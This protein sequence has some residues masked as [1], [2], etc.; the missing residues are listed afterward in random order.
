MLKVGLYR[1]RDSL[2]RPNPEIQPD[3]RLNILIIVNDYLALQATFLK[4]NEAR[5][6]QKMVKIN[7]HTKESFLIELQILADIQIY[8]S[9]L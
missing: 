8:C 7:I 4:K 2:L 3:I 9:R 1:I 5:Y 6:Y